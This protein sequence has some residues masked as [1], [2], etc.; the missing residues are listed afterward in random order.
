[1][2]SLGRTPT[3]SLEPLKFPQIITAGKD[4]MLQ[5]KHNNFFMVRFFTAAK[6]RL[7]FSHSNFKNGTIFCTLLLYLKLHNSSNK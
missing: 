3:R 1:M 5:T 2:C 6:L 7:D 4:N